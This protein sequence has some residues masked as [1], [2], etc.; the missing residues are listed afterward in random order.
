L[1]CFLNF[2]IVI[3]VLIDKFRKGNMM[4]KRD[5]ST[6]D[7]VDL[8]LVHCSRTCAFGELTE[9]QEQT[10]M[11]TNNDRLRVLPEVIPRVF[12]SSEI[13][14]DV[15]KSEFLSPDKIQQQR[16]LLLRHSSK[17]PHVDGRCPITPYCGTMKILW[18]HIIYCKNPPTS[19]EFV[20]CGSSRVL[21]KHYA[22]C[23]VKS[24]CTCY[25][26]REAVINNYERSLVKKN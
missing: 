6:L 8:D 9:E 19:C 25:P 21:L 1:E 20:H 22:N 11:Q 3:F 5:I 14:N 10:K 24:C 16:L 2:R 4:R 17:C 15:N 12:I 26:V 7:L 23:K 13:E 18:A